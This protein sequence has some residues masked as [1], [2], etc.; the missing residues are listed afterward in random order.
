MCFLER[1]EWTNRVLFSCVFKHCENYTIGS[2]RLCITNV[3]DC[4]V[5]ASWRCPAFQKDIKLKL[6]PG[7]K[8]E[9]S[10]S[11]AYKGT[12]HKNNLFSSIF[13]VS[14]FYLWVK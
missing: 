3:S 7:N 2:E 11:R 10:Q 9:Y 4:A 6:T 12:T 14:H 1:N 8:R 5:A 13:S